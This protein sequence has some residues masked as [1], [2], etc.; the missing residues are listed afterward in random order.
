MSVTANTDA[1]AGVAGNAANAA[2]SS[3]LWEQLV[4]LSGGSGSTPSPEFLQ[5]LHST[6]S[7]I[8]R[9][10]VDIGVALREGNEGFEAKKAGTS[11]VFGDDQLAVD[12]TSDNAVFNRLQ[13]SGVV[14]TGSSEETVEEKALGGAGDNAFSVAFDPLDGSSIVDANF[15]VGSIFGVYPGSKLKDRRGKEQVLSCMAMYG[16]RITMA[17]AVAPNGTENAGNG[18]A[19]FELTYTSAKGW[20]ATSA[21]SDSKAPLALTIAPAG[22]VFAPGNLRATGDHP[23][24]SNLVQHWISSGYTL[25]YT[26]GMVPDVYHILS[27]KKGV[28][29]NVE[30][31]KATAKLRLLYEVAPIA[32][33]I[34]AA[35]G[36]SA[37]TLADETGAGSGR[38][39]VLNMLVDDLDRRVGVCYGGTEEV[40]KFRKII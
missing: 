27:K 35:G 5:N 2:I 38:D 26:G 30:S 9:S 1:A 3:E 18:K 24:Y 25:R 4:K 36:S 16:P 40:E 12:V 32:L 37:S 14:A 11:N 31:A 15:T 23:E 22:K 17:V 39:S 19:A 21:G 13:A 28:F 34:E 6:F 20:V 10:V 7:A 29:S 8:C 33:I